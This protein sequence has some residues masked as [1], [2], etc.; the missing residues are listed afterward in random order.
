MNQ[1][2]IHKRVLELVKEVEDENNEINE[3]KEKFTER[4]ITCFELGYISALNEKQK[5]IITKSIDE[6]ADAM[7]FLRIDY[8][9][10]KFYEDYEASGKCMYDFVTEWLQR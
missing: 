5:P 9:G 4:D 6:I 3:C 2:Q 1:V 8:K 10:S 7:T